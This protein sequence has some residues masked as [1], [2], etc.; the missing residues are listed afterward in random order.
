MKE[1]TGADIALSVAKG[2]GLVLLIVFAFPV[3]LIMQLLKI[4][5]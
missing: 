1:K 5:D 3:L 2:L 4:S